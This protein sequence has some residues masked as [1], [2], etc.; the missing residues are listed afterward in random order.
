MFFY[1]WDGRYLKIK[2]LKLEQT[3]ARFK[4]KTP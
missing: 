2:S 1:I 3:P 4:A